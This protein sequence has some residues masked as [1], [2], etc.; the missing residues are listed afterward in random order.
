MMRW[1]SS[2]SRNRA[3]S[4]SLFAATLAPAARAGGQHVVVVSVLDARGNPMTGLTAA[5]FR[6]DL[7]GQPVTVSS[8]AEDTAPRRVAVVI[9]VSASQ[10]G[11]SNRQFAQ[12]EQLIDRLL[13][14]QS[15]A[16]FT[17]SGTLTKAS[18]F[19]A[20][21]DT[22][23]KAMRD[24]YTAGVSG[25]SSLYDGIVEVVAA[26]ADP[27]PGDAICLFSDGDDTSSRRSATEAARIAAE[28]N[29]R[30]FLL[31]DVHE[32]LKG[33]VLPAKAAWRD[34]TDA[35]GGSTAWFDPAT[36]GPDDSARA[37][38]EVAAAIVTCYRL[39]V[40]LARPLDRPRDWRLQAI[41]SDGRPLQH[42]R[43]FYPRLLLPSPPH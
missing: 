38:S 33:G 37:T 14:R 7:L 6:G 9:D 42:V 22:I 27:R 2:R 26:F 8:S 40:A 11:A 28:K 16:L 23:R 25:K 18:D 20:E 24:A 39:E 3:V 19:T 15:I 32:P 29:V 12:A 1:R 41:G 43:L 5:S 30:I 21:P 36:Q 34:I 31:G 17:I 35:T 4:L 13:P 10:A